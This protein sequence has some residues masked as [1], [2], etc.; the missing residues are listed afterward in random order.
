MATKVFRNTVIK[1]VRNKNETGPWLLLTMEK[2]DGTTVD[3]RIYNQNAVP[4]F[5]VEGVYDV[6]YEKDGKWWNAI[7]AELV[8]VT[9]SVGGTSAPKLPPRQSVT[10]NGFG[11]NEILTNRSI[12]SQVAVKACAEIVSSAIAAKLVKDQDEILRLYSYSLDTV[13]E[14][15]KGFITGASGSQLPNTST[16]AEVPKP[17][18]ALAGSE[19]G[20]DT[21]F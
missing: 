9:S 8:G 15:M 19:V 4:K 3:K 2:D 12:T 20:E 13:L 16:N 6:T 11:K 5:S 18:V 21:P 10:S 17:E 7:D 14:K 1:I